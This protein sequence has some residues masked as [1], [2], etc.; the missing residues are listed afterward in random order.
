MDMA[1]PMVALAK[2]IS[3]KIR[4]KQGGISEVPNTNE[5]KIAYLIIFYL[6]YYLNKVLTGCPL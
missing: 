1:K 4:D 5:M 3:T 2:N 6:L